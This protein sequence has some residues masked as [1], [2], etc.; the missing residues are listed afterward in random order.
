MTFQGM[1]MGEFKLVMAWIQSELGIGDRMVERFSPEELPKLMR[2]VQIRQKER[3]GLALI[4]GGSPQEGE[5]LIN[6]AALERAALLGGKG[7]G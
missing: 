4:A 6:E 3:M 2:L 7:D 1:G 5:R